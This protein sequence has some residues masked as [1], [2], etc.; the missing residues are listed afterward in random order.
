MKI[1]PSLQT[2]IGGCLL[3]LLAASVSMI[4]SRSPEGHLL[5]S[6]IDIYGLACGVENVRSGG[7]FVQLKH[8]IRFFESYPVCWAP[9]YLIPLL[10]TTAISFATTLP[11]LTVAIWLTPLLVFGIGVLFYQIT[12]QLFQRTDLAWIIA[13]LSVLTPSIQRSASL[14]PHNLY[15]YLGIL[16]FIFFLIRFQHSHRWPAAFG[17]AGATVLLLF[18]H[19]LSFLFL[20]TVIAITLL[21][22]G[23]K[24]PMRLLQF[25]LLLFILLVGYIIGNNIPFIHD[26]LLSF[27]AELTFNQQFPPSSLHP[28]WNHPF[29]WGP[30]LTLLGILGLF[31]WRKN[32]LPLLTFWI[33]MLLVSI[34]FAHGSRFGFYIVPGRIVAYAFIPLLIFSGLTLKQWRMQYAAMF[35]SLLLLIFS[36]FIAQSITIQ[37]SNLQ[38]FGATTQPNEM[39]LEAEHELQNLPKKGGALLTIVRADDRPLRTS[40]L[41]YD[42]P[43][44]LYP[45]H[46]LKRGTELRPKEGT[47]L[48]WLFLQKREEVTQ[49]LQ[50]LFELVQH[51]R[52][53]ENANLLK[54]MKVHYLLI[55]TTDRA[56]KEKLEGGNGSTFAKRF[57][58]SSYAIYEYKKFN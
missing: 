55:S 56:L 34:V 7:S 22:L 52:A 6:S 41:F 51:P 31:H 13:F 15:G 10:T 36:A 57:E 8:E 28:W 25:F 49:P 35:P 53:K 4:A 9:T 12:L 48:H 2:L 27:Q 43:N 47:Y 38:T 19:S 14:T 58:N 37:L 54:K 24:N 39:L 20:T 3:L 23:W 44:L 40:V 26:A 45:E 1:S 46:L 11:G 17:M 5:P 29:A 42:G 21:L 33:S 50:D 30:I 32:H 18:T 16:C